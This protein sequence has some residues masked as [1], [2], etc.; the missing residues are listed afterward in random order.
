MYCNS[1]RQKSC[2]FFYNFLVSPNEREGIFWTQC[3]TAKGVFNL[4]DFKDVGSALQDSIANNNK[5]IVEKMWKLLPV[6][7]LDCNSVLNHN[8]IKKCV[9]LM[10]SLKGHNH[11]HESITPWKEQFA[12]PSV[13]MRQKSN[14]QWRFPLDFILRTSRENQTDWTCSV[15][16]MWESMSIWHFTSA[17][18]WQS[19]T[20]TAPF[21]NWD[22]RLQ[23]TRQYGKWCMSGFDQST[24]YNLFATVGGS[25]IQSTGIFPKY[26]CWNEDCSQCR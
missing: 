22:K 6:T 2:T 23:I 26:Y 5:K 21:N 15:S 16:E 8:L 20:T 9:A 7:V 11:Q 19:V 18:F 10:P 12:R 14:F 3:S 17:S 24:S 4:S 25:E 13:R 1:D